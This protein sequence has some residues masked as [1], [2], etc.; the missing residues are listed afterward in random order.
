MSTLVT[1]ACIRTPTSKTAQPSNIITKIMLVL[2]FCSYYLD[3]IQGDTWLTFIVMEYFENLIKYG[4]LCFI[5]SL[6]HIHINGLYVSEAK[7]RRI[8][9]GFSNEV[10]RFS[11]IK[12]RCSSFKE[13]F[14]TFPPA[15]KVPTLYIMG[16]QYS[17]NKS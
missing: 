13:N 5:L 11:W 2:S 15:L 9:S 17:A 6:L 14:H 4:Y 7:D 16:I 10:P 3:M 8:I 12:F 1:L